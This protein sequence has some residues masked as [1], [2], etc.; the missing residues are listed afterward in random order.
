MRN[1]TKGYFTFTTVRYCVNLLIAVK[2]IE[3]LMNCYA[4]Q[5]LIVNL[6]QLQLEH[7]LIFHGLH[8]HFLILLNVCEFKFY[9]I[10]NKGSISD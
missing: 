10:I 7:K 2:I 4:V 6:K 8:V 1:A 5:H 9:G 3:L